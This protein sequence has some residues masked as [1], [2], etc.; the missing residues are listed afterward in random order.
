MIFFFGVFSTISAVLYMWTCRLIAVIASL[1]KQF[2]WL[3]PETQA[4]SQLP[5]RKHGCSCSLSTFEFL[6]LNS[7]TRQQQHL[8]RGLVHVDKL[9]LDHT[10]WEPLLPGS[11]KQAFGDWAR[12]QMINKAYI[13][14]LIILHGH[15]DTLHCH[16]CQR[17]TQIKRIHWKLAQF[18][19]GKEDRRRQH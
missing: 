19:Q 14:L 15:G 17:E 13:K 8:A 12:R 7:V 2:S 4:Y 10:L 1:H 11:L 5:H 3:S 16:L 9:S 18:C 6:R